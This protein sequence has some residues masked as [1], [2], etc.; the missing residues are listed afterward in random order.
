MCFVTI[1]QG[2]RGILGPSDSS[3]RIYGR[4][5]SVDPVAVETRVSYLGNVSLMDDRGR[6]PKTCWN[7]HEIDPKGHGNT[8]NTQ[9]SSYRYLFK[10]S[11]TYFQQLCTMVTFPYEVSY[12][13][14]VG[15][16]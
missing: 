7:H 9:W 1:Y 4:F 11:S 14:L 6:E 10:I 8:S 3:F 13:T 12:F 15:S 2:P 16:S 5:S